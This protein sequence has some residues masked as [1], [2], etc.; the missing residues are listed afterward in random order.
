MLNNY[1]KNVGSTK[2]IIGN[3]CQNHTE[4]IDWNADYDGDKAKILIKTNSDGHK[5]KI[6]LTLDNNDLANL[7]NVDSV[8]TPIHSRLKNDFKKKIF[9]D[10]PNLYRIE[11][12]TPK[13]VPRTP[14]YFSDTFD[15]EDTF[16]S[17][18]TF[19]PSITSES[20][21]ELLNTTPDNFLSSPNM[22]DEFIVLNQKPYKKYTFTPK[23]RNL[24]FK[25]HKTYRVFKRPKS[26]RSKRRRFSRRS[27]KG[28]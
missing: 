19:D 27:S 18:D 24:T 6:H 22:N 9:I 17:E 13:L 10:N 20:L 7:F 28:G 15:P 11:L 3:R 23:K 25:K 1:I 12:P 26:V 8:N 16:D 4:K 2:T 14:L 5:K 21:S